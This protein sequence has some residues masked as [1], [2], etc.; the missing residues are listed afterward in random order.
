MFMPY[1]SRLSRETSPSPGT[2]L[3]DTSEEG[4]VCV[5]CETAYQ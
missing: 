3:R 4:R 5:S 2:R 1:S